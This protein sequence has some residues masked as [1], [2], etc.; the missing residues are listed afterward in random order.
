MRHRIEEW[1]PTAEIDEAGR[2]R[3]KQVHQEQ[4]L[5]HIAQARQHAILRR[6]G[7]LRIVH[8]DRTLPCL[9]QD[10]NEDDDDAQ[11][12]EPMRHHA[13]KEDAERL[14]L[15]ARHDR[16]PRPRETGDA[17]EQ[18]VEQAE[19]TA[20]KVRQHAEC[21]RQQPADARDGRPLAHRHLSLP[22]PAPQLQKPADQEADA[23]RDRERQAARLPVPESYPQRHDKD[24]G[25][26]HDQAAEDIAYEIVI[27]TIP[28]S[29]K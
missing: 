16:R 18:A 28:L 23:H 26:C 11:A 6:A 15:N 13:P 9:G 19:R 21:R 12:A 29:A 25:F 8:V 24:Q 3:E 7:S 4:D 10:G 2:R 17:L 27:H 1:Q 5:R 14:R 20:Q 22:R